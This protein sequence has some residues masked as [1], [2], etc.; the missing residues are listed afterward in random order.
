MAGTSG[1][2]SHWRK[3]ALWEEATRSPLIWVAPGLT[4]AGTKSDRPIDFMSIYPTLTDLCSVPTPKHVEGTSIRPLLGN[5][6][7]AWT[8]P[9][10]TTY[11]YKNHTARSSDWRYIRYENGDEELYDERKDPHEYV[12]LAGKPEFA[13]KKAELAKFFPQTDL[14][15]PSGRDETKREKKG[16]RKKKAD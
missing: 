1:E 3:F 14:A 6:N 15:T 4:K 2:K 11:R 9:A 8:I 12:N 7:A 5:V 13:A 10:V 16:G